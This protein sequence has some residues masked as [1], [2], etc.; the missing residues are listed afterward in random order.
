MSHDRDVPIQNPESAIQNCLI[1]T[2]TTDDAYTIARMRQAMWDEMSPDNPAPREYRESLFVYW[3]EMLH[4]GRAVGWIAEAG[5][6]IGVAM[7]LIHDHP[8]RPHGAIRRGYVTNV[9]VAPEHRRRGVAR[10]LMETVI[11]YGREHGLQRLEL[12]TSDMGRDLYESVGFEPAEFLIL[13]LDQDPRRHANT[14]EDQL[15]EQEQREHL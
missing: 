15:A 12:R 2:A 13:R 4:S 3:H 9:Y 6:A 1:R 10:R 5:G 11:A 14:G 7:L 8:P